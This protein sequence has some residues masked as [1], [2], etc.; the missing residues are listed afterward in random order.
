MLNSCR[1]SINGIGKNRYS[2]LC[3]VSRYLGESKPERP[4]PPERFQVEMDRYKKEFTERKTLRE[5]LKSGI[6]ALR[7][8]ITS[9]GPND[10]PT[11]GQEN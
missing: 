8:N 2:D 4:A 6:A 11:N 3:K 1:L 10:I 5:R 7:R 9:G